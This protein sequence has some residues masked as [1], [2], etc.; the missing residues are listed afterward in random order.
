MVAQHPDLLKVMTRETLLIYWLML[1]NLL[2]VFVHNALDVVV[3][4]FLHFVHLTRMQTC[5]APS[6]FISSPNK[7]SHCIIYIDIYNL[8]IQI[9]R[10][11]NLQICLT[12]PCGRELRKN[13]SYQKMEDDGR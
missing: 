4:R 9:Q 13:V 1:G 5:L 2:V 3:L 12:Q 6:E 10:H 8:P 7:A 11:F